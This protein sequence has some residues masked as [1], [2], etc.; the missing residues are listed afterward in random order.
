MEFFKMF[1]TPFFDEMDKG[2]GAANA[3]GNASGG[4]ADPNAGQG[5][6]QGG[7]QGGNQ[8]GNPGGTQGGDP[9]TEDVT[10]TQ[11]FAHRLKEATDKERTKALDEF[12]AG[13]GYTYNG[14]PIT[15]YAEYKKAQDEVKAQQDR[16]KFKQDNGFDPETVKPLFEQWKQ[17]DPDFQELRSIRQEKNVNTALNDLNNELKD[18]G[19]DIVLKDLSA[20]ELKKVPNI[21][22]VTEYVQ[23]GHSLADA[24]WLA[25]KK[26]ILSVQIQKTQQETVKRIAANGAASPGS[27]AAGG[28]SGP[29]DVWNMSSKDFK[30]MQEKALRG[31]LKKS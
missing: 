29:T 25:N 27:L 10:Q 6:S 11:A 23:K 22:K 19:L 17:N 26:D 24:F 31:E 5:G 1:K 21:A 7:A 16:D 12:I 3:G 13:E 14:K 28:E 4:I 30:E 8:G 9:G 15:T 20:E 18:N 2:G